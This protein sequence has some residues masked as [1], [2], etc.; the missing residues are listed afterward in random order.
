MPAQANANVLAL[1][2][3]KVRDKVP[4]LYERDETAWLEAMSAL[5][6]EGYAV[7][8]AWDAAQAFERFLEAIGQRIIGR[9]H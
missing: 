6:A 1:Q 4:L 9:R 5:I 7:D 2:L 8:H 3:E